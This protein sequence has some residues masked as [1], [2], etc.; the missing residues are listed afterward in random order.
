MHNVHDLKAKFLP[1]IADLFFVSILLYLFFSGTS[2]LL[3]DCDTGYHIR[4]GEYILKTLSIPKFDIFSLHTPPIPW[5]A[6]EW[7]SEVIMAVVHT[8]FGLSGI[9]A[10]F[11]F[12]LAL[13]TY[14]LFKILVA[15]GIDILLSACITILVFSSS[16]L[17]WLARP[18]VFSLLLM[19]FSHYLLESWRR[20][21]SNRLYLLPPVMLLWVNLH[22]GFLGGFLLMGAYLTGLI[23]GLFFGADS[24]PAARA[25]GRQKL[26]QLGLTIAFCLA[27]CIVNPNGYHILLFPFTLV[28]NRFLM[29]NISEFLSPDFHQWMPFKYLL[30]LLIAILAVS[31]RTIEATELVLI[32]IF[33]N[34]ALYSARYIP[35]FALVTAP[36]VTRKADEAREMIGGRFAEF[37][38]KRSENLAAINAGATS[39]FWPA[40]AVIIVL[41]AT[42]SGRFPHHFDPKIKAVAACEFMMKERITGNMFN[43]DEF[44]DYFIY[45]SSPAYKVFMDGR[46]DMYGTQRLKEYRKISDFEP[47]W[48]GILDKYH[49]TWI[50]FGSDSRL[51]R[52]LLTDKDWV[53]IYSDKVADIFVKNLQQ[54]RPLIEKYRSVKQ[55]VF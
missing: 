37:Y 32:M 47:G 19:V 18:H 43:D 7:L 34:M 31:R 12:I 24:A 16:Q 25:A 26:K 13:T 11:A 20:D 10:F 15:Y 22:G 8:Q 23:F 53:L 21:R 50:C 38:R 42:L 49:I 35:L 44:G 9:V 48:E 5:T 46:S 17:H 14:L 3:D 30:L 6:H 4:T 41:A 27:A 29:D 45:R 40:A 51:S 28:S 54:Y 55:V 36:I 33:T 39:L 2:Q 1:S 52:Y